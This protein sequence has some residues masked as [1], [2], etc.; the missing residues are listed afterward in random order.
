MDTLM[1]LMEVYKNME[2]K[3]LN[4]TNLE[5]KYQEINILYVLGKLILKIFSKVYLS[6]I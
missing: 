2:S 3:N 4:C 5:R 1:V 6:Y